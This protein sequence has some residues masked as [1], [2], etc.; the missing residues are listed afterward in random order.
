M[1]DIRLQS[2]RVHQCCKRP[3]EPGEQRLTFASIALR[4]HSTM[5]RSIFETN[6]RRLIRTS[7][8]ERRH[9]VCRRTYTLAEKSDLLE[10]PNFDQKR[11]RTEPKCDTV[12]SFPD[13]YFW[14]CYIHA[15]DRIQ[16]NQERN[17]VSLARLLLVPP[18]ISCSSGRLDLGRHE[19]CLAIWSNALDEFSAPLCRFL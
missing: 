5:H 8:L 13:T 17:E 9:D 14:C 2:I 11:K 16:Y 1:W 10:F 18:A 3:S 15:T 7:A 6:T 4:F 12:H 19:A